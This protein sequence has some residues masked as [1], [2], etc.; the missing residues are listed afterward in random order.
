MIILT[1]IK[2]VSSLG[3]W[4]PVVSECEAGWHKGPWEKCCPCGR[5]SSVGIAICAASAWCHGRQPGV[6]YHIERDV[7]T[8]T[9]LTATAWFMTAYAY[10][11]GENICL[12]CSW[13][14][15]L[16][17]VPCSLLRD[18]VGSLYLHQ[19]LADA[20]DVSSAWTEPCSSLKISNTS[21]S[22][23]LQ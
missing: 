4:V 7:H 1:L 12:S 8:G 11:L 20:A 3:S 13:P 21:A 14:S 17:I 9:V 18:A 22:E 5:V 16:M 23:K 10:S 15:C 6:E 19:L 2:G